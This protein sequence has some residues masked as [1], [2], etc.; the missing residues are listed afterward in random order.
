MPSLGLAFR[1]IGSA[2]L[3]HV[4]SQSGDEKGTNYNLAN[5]KTGF[6][7]NSSGWNR[8]TGLV[9]PPIEGSRTPSTVKPDGAT[10]GLERSGGLDPPSRLW[11]EM[12]VDCF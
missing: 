2:F 12:E 7:I 1:E 10:S 11:K 5:G 6:G 9:V 3:I 4:M 8:N